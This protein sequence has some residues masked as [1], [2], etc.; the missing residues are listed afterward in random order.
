MPPAVLYVYPGALDQ[1]RG[2]IVF[3]GLSAPCA[4]GRS[5]V[6]VRK[7]E[8]DGATPVATMRPV[9]IYWRADR[10][11]RPRTALPIRPIR[12]DDGWC[13]DVAHR[14][15][16]RSVRLPFPASHEAMRRTDGLYDVVVEL[17][18]NRAPAVRGRGSAIFLHL[19]KPDLSPTQGCIAVSIETMRRILPRLRPTTRIIVRPS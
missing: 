14:R 17:D 5:G 9:A 15:Y 18:W 16:N 4:L 3:A 12:A 1:R 7:R 11:L 19:A 10:L 13:D 8:G 2:R 6:K